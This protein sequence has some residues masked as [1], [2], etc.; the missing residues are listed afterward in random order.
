MR[1]VVDAVCIAGATVDGVGAGLRHEGVV[2][3]AAVERICAGGAVV[4]GA[5]AKER[6]RAD[7][8]TADAQTHAVL[9]VNGVAARAD[10]GPLGEV[11]QHD[12]VAAAVAL[13]PQL[14]A[15]VREVAH[16]G[17]VEGQA[18]G[19]CCTGVG[20]GQ[21]DDFNALGAGCAVFHKVEAARADAQGVG[22]VAAVDQAVSAVIDQ[23]VIAHAGLQHVHAHATVEG[24]VTGAGVEQVRACAASH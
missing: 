5:R 10:G 17:Q 23:H 20:V 15:V 16:A 1:C 22:A 2:A 24:V 11:L 19:G 14:F 13:H 8:G 12:A 9:A 7:A 3:V 4:G 21:V 18:G 6:G